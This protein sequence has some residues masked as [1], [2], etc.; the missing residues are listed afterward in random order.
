MFASIVK[1]T[2]TKA[3]SHSAPTSES[4]ASHRT[5]SDRR[6]GAAALQGIQTELRVG[7]INDPLEHEADRI[8]DEVMG[9]S[10]GRPTLSTGPP[11]LHRK[12][13]A[14]EEEEK[15]DLR[16]TPDEML[17]GS[18]AEAPAIVHDVIH[19]P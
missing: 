10:V 1:A 9:I 16:R 13:E 12:C 3:D 5:L 11:H 18:G 8:A 17:V 15:S 4:K 6:P 7:Q 14:C 2:K 19:S